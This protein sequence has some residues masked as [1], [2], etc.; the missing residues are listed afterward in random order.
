MPIRGVEEKPEYLG[1]AL[2]LTPEFWEM[3]DYAMQQ[4][5]SLDLELGIHICDG[6]ALAGGPWI[7]PEESMQKVVWSDTIIHVTKHQQHI[8]LPQAAEGYQGYYEDIAAFACPVSGDGIAPLPIV[9]GTILPDEN[10][11]YRSKEPGY[12]QYSYEQPQTVRSIEIIPS[13][14]NVQ[15]QR[16]L[17]QVI[18]DGEIFH[19]VRQ[20]TPPRQGWQNTDQ[21][22][23]YALPETTARY[24]R[25]V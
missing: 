19:D 14:N 21:N 4:C 17:V 25:F 20:L 9:S 23:T 3:A 10:G 6:F 18:D 11:T 8:T 5:D 13:G 24:F 16:L 12:I 7:S 22:Y 1:K 15:S 2:Q